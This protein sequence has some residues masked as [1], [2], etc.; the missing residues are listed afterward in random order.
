MHPT[1][2]AWG[3]AVAWWDPLASDADA[4]Y[5]DVVTFDAADIAPT[6]TWGITPGQGIAVD[7]KVPA[8]EELPSEDASPAGRGLPLHGPQARSA[9]RR[10]SI[11]VAFIGSC[12]NGRIS[13][14][15]EAV[16]VIQAHGGSGGRARHRLGRP[17]L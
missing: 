9:H 14:L 17:R 10:S 3:R 2:E 5:D 1:G 15:R 16:K 13:D 11:D 8:S 7:E 4:S 12:T 6:V